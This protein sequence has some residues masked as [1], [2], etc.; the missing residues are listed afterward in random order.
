MSKINWGRVFLGGLLATVVLLGL[1]TVT[2]ILF[3]GPFLDTLEELGHPLQVT[4]GFVIASVFL[5]L[6]GSVILVWLYAAI[7][8]RYGPGPKTAA[9]VGFVMWL[10]AAETT[11]LVVLMVSIPA[12]V[13]V[14]PILAALPSFV[15][16]TIAG[17][18]VYQEPEGAAAVTS[19]AG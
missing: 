15:V 3:L 14:I 11:A 12:G 8:P 13:T 6:G 5:Y 16:A 4:T 1:Q 19:E 7:R 10:F 2:S 18:W 9:L 17:A